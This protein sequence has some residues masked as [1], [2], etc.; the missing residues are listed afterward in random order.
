MLSLLVYNHFTG[1]VTQFASIS[2]EVMNTKNVTAPKG[3]NTK[4][5]TFQILQEKNV[6][7]PCNR[8]SLKQ[9]V[10]PDPVQLGGQ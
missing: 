10:G 9:K 1:D 8:C 2:F 4:N 5:S 6:L 3:D 7:N